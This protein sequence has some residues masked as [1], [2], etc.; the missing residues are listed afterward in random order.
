MSSKFVYLI[1]VLGV[2]S[3]AQARAADDA[4]AYLV[5][6]PERAPVTLAHGGCVRTSQWTPDS[7]YGPCQPLPFRVAMDALFDFDSAVLNIDAERALDALTQHLAEADYQKVEIIG[8]ADRIGRA[9]YNR[10]LSE[11]RAQAVRDYLVA[12]GMDRSK[13]AISGLGSVES[14]TRSLCE[15]FHGEALVQCLQPDRSAEVTV[16]GTQASAMR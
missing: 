5:S 11:Q 12:Q 3:V 13:I 1:A 8:R 4:A 16:I 14:A 7:S 10:K 2:M 9:D 6:G 15:S